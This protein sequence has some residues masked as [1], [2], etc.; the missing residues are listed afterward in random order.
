MST[1][2]K[3][4]ARKSPTA[5]LAPDPYLY[6]WRDTK[7]VAPDGTV[8]F[9]QVPLSLEDVLFPEEGDFIVQT[10]GHIADVVYLRTVFKAQ[11]SD[12][13][14]VAVV[15]DGRVDWNLPGVKPLS[16][17]I[18]VFRGV[19]RY[20]NWN[21]FDVAAE[22]AKPLLVV[23]VTSPTTRQNDL[24]IKFDFY[25]RAEVPFY[26]IADVAVAGEERHIE[27]SGY[28]LTQNEYEL[29][30]PDSRGR[31]Y[32]E[33]VRLWVGVTVDPL[34][35]FERLACYDPDT[36][37]EL[38][39]FLAALKNVARAREEALTAKRQARAAKRKARAEARARGDAESRAEAESRARAE[40]ESRA[41]AEARARAEAEQRIRAL[42][43]ELNRSRRQ[44]P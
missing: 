24:G 18:A 16:P 42:E 14:S 27:L 35:G 9:D 37:E 25:F 3:S 7:V 26:L 32:L 1:V 12:D 29:V 34:G 17:D 11:T 28:Q 39:D 31:I 30:K 2:S 8:T 33:A 44:E 6:G 23:E 40:A 43:A 22:G 38:G 20:C 5:E 36:G 10:E 15:A 4:S 41:E 13:P 19:R 21:T